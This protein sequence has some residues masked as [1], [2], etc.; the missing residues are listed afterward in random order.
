MF[1]DPETDVAFGIIEIAK[2]QR[3]PRTNFYASWALSFSQ[4]MPTPGAFTGNTAY[5]I[6]SDG[7]G[8]QIAGTIGAR[9]FAV[10]TSDTTVFIH[11]YC[12]IRSLKRCA[13]GANLGTGR[14]L[15]VITHFWHE[16]TVF[17]IRIFITIIEAIDKIIRV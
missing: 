17:Y 5:T 10:Q 3:I 6:R 16:E 7:N 9:L 11:Q 13:L 15:A 1:L 8:T 14:F 4:P 2:N 12:A